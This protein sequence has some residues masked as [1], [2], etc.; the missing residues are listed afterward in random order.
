MTT[1]LLEL[2]LSDVASKIVEIL[3]KI[4]LEH[5]LLEPEGTDLISHVQLLLE[6]EASNSAN[7]ASTPQ[8]QANYIPLP[9][10][11]DLTRDY[12]DIVNTLAEYE[13]ILDR[14]LISELQ[15]LSKQLGITDPKETLRRAI[16]NMSKESPGNGVNNK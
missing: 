1:R 15:N 3:A 5:G 11:S 10:E 7:S 14:D 6:T 8:S 13:T 9:D 4:S 2:A 16:K 12:D